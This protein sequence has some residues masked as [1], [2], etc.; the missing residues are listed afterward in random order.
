MKRRVVLGIFRTAD[1]GVLTVAFSL[2]FLV[3]AQASPEA[4]HF[5]SVRI[6]L[7]N[8]L[9]FIGFAAAWHLLFSYCGL[10]RSPVLG[11]VNSWWN[12]AKAGTLGTLLLTALAH[13]LNLAAVDRVFM[14]VFLVT[15]VLGTQV[16][17]S[18][19]GLVIGYSQSKTSNLTRVMIVG[20]GP[21]GTLLGR[22][23]WKRPELGYL[24]V[25]YSDDIPAP[26]SPLHGR[27]E[28]LLGTLAEFETVVENLD[29]DE[30]FVTLP[31]KSYY[32]TIEEIITFCGESG[33]GVH[34]PVDFFK[35]QL[36]KGRIDYFG[37]TACL[38]YQTPRPVALRLALKR[39]TDLVFAAAALAVLSPVFAL[40][41]LAIKLDSRGTVFFLQ[42]RVGWRG[43]KFRILKFRT[44]VS[45]AEARI[46]ELEQSNEVQGAAFK[47]KEDP[48]LTRLGLFL[49][50]FSLDELPQFWNVLKGDMSL[51]GPRP[52]PLRD[53]GRFD[54]WHKRRFSVKPGLT[55][56]WQASG[57]H[58]IAFEH[59]ME[60][61]LQY[62]DN[63][64]L[65]LDFQIIFKTLPAM[66]RGTGT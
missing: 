37:N 54:H 26:E 65:G 35:P 13:L 45:G 23:I 62:I 2:A 61:D 10:Y 60:L 36:A 51:V 66:V 29:I 53:V 52:L 34:L 41:A 19:L 48:R 21:R 58:A 42:E 14:A 30:V 3:S 25:G 17:R 28:R 56:L 44:M 7:S 5:L 38:S 9:L 8:L 55:C 33:V 32:E 15:A 49:R 12:V 40:T 63:W 57:R 4:Q 47:M 20:C 11:R 6:K 43:R 50:K 31:V 24:L 64:S 59:W 22:E 16:T 39:V 46:G 1:L 27:S 18:V